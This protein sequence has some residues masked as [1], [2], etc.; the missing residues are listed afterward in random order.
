MGRIYTATFS[1]QSESAACD[2]FEIVAGSSDLI[3]LHELHIAQNSDVGD[4]EEEMLRIV[5]SSGHTTGGSGGGTITPVP[6]LLGDAASGATV[7]HT[8]TSRASGG[9]IVNHYEWYWNVR[10]P[11]SHLWTPESRPIL[12]PSRRAIVELDTTPSDAL[13]LSGTLVFEELG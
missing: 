9:T 4:A 3:V 5:L 11:F 10:I 7:E 8:N 2:L 12:I 1:E 13:T 6:R